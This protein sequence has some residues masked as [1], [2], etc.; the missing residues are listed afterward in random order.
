VPTLRPQYP[1][2]FRAEA[3]RLVREGGDLLLPL[4]ARSWPSNGGA[5]PDAAHGGPATPLPYSAHQKR[6][7][8]SLAASVGVRFVEDEELKR[9]RSA[10][11]PRGFPR[12]FEPPLRMR[13][14]PR[15]ALW[16]T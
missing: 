4:L 11:R 2:E 13:P 10:I 16:P 3:I 9:W 15:G 1:A 6:N 7:V 8:G 12:P 5:R 14:P